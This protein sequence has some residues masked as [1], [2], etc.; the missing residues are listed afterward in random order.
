[1]WNTG[2]PNLGVLTVA[3]L[4]YQPLTSDA[5]R[6]KERRENLSKL[7]KV[8]YKNSLERK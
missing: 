1:M 8:V 3:R 2:G 5:A 4:I 6:I 7:K